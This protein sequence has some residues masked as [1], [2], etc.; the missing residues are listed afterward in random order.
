MEIREIKN[1]R[2]L[3]S[4]AIDC[5]VLFVG[6]NDFMP[7]T[8]TPD[9]TAETGRKVWQ[10]LQSGEWGEIA[11]FTVTPEMLEAARAAKRQEINAWRTEQE[12]QPFTF[13]WNGHTWNA[14]PDS[15]ARL[16]PVTMA[17]KSENSRDTFAWNDASN[18]PVQMTMMQAEE[19][20]AAMAQA[21]LDR[22]DDIYVRQREMKDALEK[23]GDLNSIRE[24]KIQ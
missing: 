22:N 1:A 17:A 9:D 24:L 4:G 11:P 12:A 20:V 3:E 6:F 16:S 5:D 18:Q 23:L 8:A 13:E 21:Q 10:E 2:C 7:Y 14:G 19:L 15:L